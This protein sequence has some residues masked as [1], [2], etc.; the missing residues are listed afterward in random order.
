M[1]YQNSDRDEYFLLQIDSLSTS[2]SWIDG[3]KAP[4][5]TWSLAFSCKS[6]HWWKFMLTLKWTA[7]YPCTTK[8]S[9][10]NQIKTYVRT[11]RSGKL[12][13]CIHKYHNTQITFCIRL[14]KK[15]SKL[16]NKL[17]PRSPNRSRFTKFRKSSFNYQKKK[18]KNK[19]IVFPLRSALSPKFTIQ[20]NRQLSQSIITRDSDCRQ[21]RNPIE[22]PN[23]YHG[24]K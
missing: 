7:I 4:Q 12:H 13:A 24:S 18:K 11:K 17:D 15:L 16:T 1:P 9:I 2:I 6:V 22:K 23:K 10:S 5:Q 19:R 8:S 3:Q 20:V 14:H 21:K